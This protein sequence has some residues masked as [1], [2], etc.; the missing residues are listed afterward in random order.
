MALT[1]AD[2][3]GL[4]LSKSS[5]TKISSSVDGN[6]FSRFELSHSKSNSIVE[7]LVVMSNSQSNRA[8]VFRSESRTFA[9]STW[10]RLTD[11]RT[12]NVLYEETFPNDIIGHTSD[13]SNPY[14]GCYD[15]YNNGGSLQSCIN[16]VRDIFV[17]QDMISFIANEV[18]SSCIAI[19]AGISCLASEMGG[20]WT[21]NDLLDFVDWLTDISEAQENSKYADFEQTELGVIVYLR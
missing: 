8:I 19:A 21:S 1:T 12:Q 3:F 17:E 5:Q 2:K 4:D 18:C 6:H 15:S 20:A 14:Q 13:Q 9:D 10:L 16:C 7:E 11:V